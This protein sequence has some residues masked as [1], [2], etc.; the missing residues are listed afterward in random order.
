MKSLAELEACKPFSH[1]SS[2][3]TS[4][5]LGR[6]MSGSRLLYHNPEPDPSISSKIFCRTK[7]IWFGTYTSDYERESE[8]K[9]CSDADWSKWKKILGA[10]KGEPRQ[11][12]IIKEPQLFS[13]VSAA[14]SNPWRQPFHPSTA[15]EHLFRLTFSSDLHEVCR[16]GE[17]MSLIAKLAGVQSN[18]RCTWS[19]RLWC[20][21]PS[22]D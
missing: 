14:S 15:K 18:R 7:M 1:Q 8:R 22:C 2:N 10:I 19:D 3:L 13:S 12:F 16:F 21:I 17:G 4:G 20:Y 11:D 9:R 5:R 6:N